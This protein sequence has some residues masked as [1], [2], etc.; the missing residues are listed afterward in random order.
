MREFDPE[1]YLSAI[2]H[3][4]RVRR[5][6]CCTPSKRARATTASLSARYGSAAR[7]QREYDIYEATRFLYT[8]NNPIQTGVTS[9]VINPR[10]VAMLRGNVI[11]SDRQPLPGVSISIKD[12]PEYGQTLSRADGLFDFVLNGGETVIVEFQKT[13]YLPIQRRIDTHRRQFEV[14]EPVALI[15]PDT[16]TTAIDPASTVDFQVARGSIVSD[17]SGSRQATLLFPQGALTSLVSAQGV[18]HAAAQLTVRATEYTVGAAG[19][20][21]MPGDLPPN[22][23]YTYAVDFSID[24]AG[25]SNVTFN[26]PVINYT[27]NLI[28]APVGSAVPAAYYDRDKGEWIPSKNGLVIFTYNPVDLPLSYIPPAVTGGGNA[29]W[30]YDADHNLTT[31]T[32]PDGGA[33]DLT[34]TDNGFRLN[35]VTLSRGARGLTYDTAGRI[36]SLSDPS[37]ITLTYDYDGPL[38]TRRTQSGPVAGAVEFTYNPDWLVGSILVNGAYSATLHYDDDDL[39]IQSGDLVISRN[40]NNGL[41]TGSQLGN[42]S[43]TWAHNVYAEAISYTAAYNSAA[44]YRID[45]ERDVRGRITRKIETIGGVTSIFDYTYDPAG[46]LRQVRKD[47]VLIG[48]YTYDSNGN[49]VS[50]NSVSATYDAQD[51]LTQLDQ[52]SYTYTAAGELAFKTTGSAVTTYQYDAAGNLLAATLSDGTQITYLV[53]ALNRRVGKR[54]NGILVLGLLYEG[55]FRPIAELDGSGAV[56]SR[57]VYGSRSNVPEYLIKGGQT[58]RIIADQL[59]SP[60]LVVNVATGQ[61]AQ[62]LDYDA[63]GNV[64]QDT[65]SGLQPFGFAGGL[66]D[67]DPGLVRFGLRDYDP[68]A[69]RWTNKDPSGFAGGDSNLYAYVS[70]DP[71]NAIDP[72]GTEE[73]SAPAPCNP[74]K[75][76]CVRPIHTTRLMPSRLGLTTSRR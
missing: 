7:S 42:V 3:P 12:R 5:A 75:P 76:I 24:E 50:A 63:W 27:E 59:G 51:R 43:D 21:A 39:L 1:P 49:R 38:L 37:G 41:V 18:L 25:Q 10:C 19:A 58:Y 17:T 69:G 13:G 9:D 36:Q 16:Q 40:S 64:L 48:D 29:Q 53:D 68:I 47:G 28:T 56:V 31:F 70:N 67:R 6:S 26:S 32:R 30:S 23:G 46:R 72:T 22:S 60:R 34:Y 52:T 71:V 57:F 2:G 54:V 33:I 14:V 55:G 65:N 45:F 74:D 66:Y 15:A 61:I 4:K 8:G 73:E 20:A 44:V 62:R 35:G 11:T